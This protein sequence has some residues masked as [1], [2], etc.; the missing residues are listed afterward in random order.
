[1]PDGTLTTLVS[2]SGS[3]G[4]LPG[5][6]IQAADGNFYGL[7]YEGG[8]HNLGTVFRLDGPPP[9][10]ASLSA[11]PGNGYV[12]L[13]WKTAP[14]AVTYKIY[15]SNIAHDPSPTMLASVTNTLYTAVGLTNGTPYYFSVRGVNEPVD[16]VASNEAVAVPSASP[17][18]TALSAS[19]AILQTS[20]LA[21]TLQMK[22]VL[23]TVPSPAPVAGKAVTFSMPNGQLLCSATT[24]SSGTAA[25][26]DVLAL[27]K[28][29]LS[30]GYVARFAGDSAYSGSSASGALIQ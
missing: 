13:S 9:A 18:P 7:T 22:A 23:N 17:R 10:P 19:A 4:N 8:T 26:N 14:G 12:Q 2:F 24:D 25:C 15:A 28:T 16:G 11:N 29:T 6:L 30:L 27:L 1:M 3:D 5:T 20:P 21:I